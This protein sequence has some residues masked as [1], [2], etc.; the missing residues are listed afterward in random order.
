MLSREA[1]RVIAVE[2]GRLACDAVLREKPDVILLD[3]RMPVMDGPAALQELRAHEETR[4]IPIVMLTSYSQVDE[5][6]IAL[7][8]DVQD[9]LTNRSIRANSSRASSNSCAGGKV[10]HSTQTA[11]C[12]PSAAL[13]AASERR[14]RLL[15]EAMPHIVWIADARGEI[16]YMNRLW[17]DY[18]GGTPDSGITAARAFAIHPDD[19]TA[20]LRAWSAALRSGL[21]FETQFRLRRASDGAFRWPLARAIP[22]HNEV[23]EIVEWVGS[24]ADI[25]DYKI[26]SERKPSSTRWA[27]S[28]QSAAPTASSIMPAPTGTPIPAPASVRR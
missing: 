22:A 25:H 10:W 20:T 9:F 7:E 19:R 27:A 8:T 24:C 4:G 12:W 23:G 14:Y 1:F 28:S 5:R 16:H 11:R 3:W 6:I 26:A 2:N 18:A 17:Y 21:P 15:A 13:N